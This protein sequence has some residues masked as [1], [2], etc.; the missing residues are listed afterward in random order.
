MLVKSSIALL[1]LL[2]FVAD[3]PRS[4]VPKIEPLLKSREMSRK[5]STIRNCPVESAFPKCAGC[6]ARL[7]L[8]R[9]S[10]PKTTTT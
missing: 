4:T 10:Q 3:L 7:G 2:Y 5:R 1:T 8:P 6:G 9:A